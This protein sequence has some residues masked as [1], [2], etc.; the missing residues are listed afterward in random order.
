[1]DEQ[2]LAGEAVDGIVPLDTEAFLG[3]L[4]DAFPN[5]KREPNGAFEWF[6]WEGP[7]SVFE[8]SW[9]PLHVLVTMRPLN[10]DNANRLIDIAAA[11]GMPLYDPQTGER[12]ALPLD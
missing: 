5:G 2:L 10:E 3:A 1:V 12:F 7:N 8:V 4:A 9:S 6:V 11:F